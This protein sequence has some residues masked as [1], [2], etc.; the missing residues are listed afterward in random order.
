MRLVLVCFVL[1][2][3]LSAR[4]V[5]LTVNDVGLAVGD[6]AR[7]TRVRLDFRDRDLRQLRRISVGAAGVGA[8]PE[9]R[10]I[11]L[12]VGVGSVGSITGLSLGGIGVGASSI[13][14]LAASGIAVG[15]QNVRSSSRP[16]TSRSATTAASR[17]G[18]SAA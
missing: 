11:I 9:L 10:G 13:K 8:G 12:G 2:T 1:P 3:V 5:D 4:V 15:G 6:E 18:R 14:G 16:C 7:V 17:V